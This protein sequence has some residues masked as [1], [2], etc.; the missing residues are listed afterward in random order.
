MC[1]MC[2]AP[3]MLTTSASGLAAR[4]ASIGAVGTQ[5][6]EVIRL[7]SQHHE[8]GSAD[9]APGR[10]RVFALVENGIDPVMTRIG[11][12]AHAIILIG[13]SPNARH[14]R[15]GGRRESLVAELYDS[16]Q[17]LEGVIGLF[18]SLGF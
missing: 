15:R 17:L 13:N 18:Q 4:N 5:A 3:A 16:G 9:L 6:R 10:L 14:E 2:P 7:L 1:S 12:Q 11:R 8:Q